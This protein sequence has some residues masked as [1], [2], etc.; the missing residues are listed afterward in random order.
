MTDYLGI[1]FRI[2]LV[3]LLNKLFFEFSVI[4]NNAVMH[5]KNILPTIPMGMSIGFGYP[6]VGCPAHVTKPDLSGQL[7]TLKSILKILQ[8]SNCFYA[9]GL[10]IFKNN[11]PAGI[12]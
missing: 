6:A 2:K 3:A 11:K 4:F 1:C 9:K 12:I 7:S 8:F 10:S 5:Q